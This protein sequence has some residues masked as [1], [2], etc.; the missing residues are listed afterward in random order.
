[1]ENNNLIKILEDNGYKYIYDENHSNYSMAVGIGDILFMLVNLQQYLISSP[2]YINLDIFITGLFRDNFESET[3]IW[4][5]NLYNNFIFR[6]KM[7]N[8]IIDNNNKIKKNDIIFFTTK[9]N[10][11]IISKIIINFNYRLI[12]NY[13]LEL[14]ASFFLYSFNEAISN[15]IKDP[16]IIIH[17]K[18]RL[19]NKY[20][21][22]QIKYNLKNFFSQIKINKFNILIMGEQ[23]MPVT[24]ESNYHNISTIYNEI[25]ELYNLNSNKILDITKK[26]IYN[27]LDYE[28]YKHDICLIN[29]AEY[30]ICFGQGGSLCSSLLLGKTI[31]FD[32]I[33]EEYFYKNENLY[34]S[35]H[36]YFKNLLPMLNFLIQIV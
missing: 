31:F 26:E 14:N 32:P 12:K 35:G 33:D 8:D 11:G 2:I 21:Y 34:N 4:F 3:K 27:N 19:N 20:N 9:F 25:K 6:I 13:S 24:Y 28:N 22:S 10:S 30:N 17:T 5:D 29:K 7:L 23:M 15:F 18:L 16:F 36:R 1:M